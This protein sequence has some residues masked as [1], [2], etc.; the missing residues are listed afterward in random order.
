MKPGMLCEGTS[1]SCLGLSGTCHVGSA[2]GAL[3]APIARGWWVGVGLS[4]HWLHPRSGRAQRWVSLLLS[5]VCKA[6]WLLLFSGLWWPRGPSEATQGQAKPTVVHLGHLW[7]E[8]DRAEWQPWEVTL[9]SPLINVSYAVLLF[10]RTPQA[11]CN[12]GHFACSPW[13]DVLS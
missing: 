11:L 10:S 8:V 2:P 12:S 7:W 3:G 13:P 6:L 1:G 4:R 5:M 9:A